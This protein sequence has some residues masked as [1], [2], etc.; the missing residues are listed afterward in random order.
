MRKTPT[1]TMQNVSQRAIT[2]SAS[3]YLVSEKISVTP[4]EIALIVTTQYA[5]TRS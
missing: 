4:K 3:M 2:Q 1:A 5:I